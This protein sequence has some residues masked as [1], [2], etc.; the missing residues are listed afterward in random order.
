[1]KKTLGLLLLTL[2]VSSFAFQEVKPSMME[3]QE[4]IGGPFGLP[5]YVTSK[6]NVSF[7]QKHPS[8]AFIFSPLVQFGGAMNSVRYDQ[9][10]KVES[11]SLNPMEKSEGWTEVHR[12]RIEVGAGLSELARRTLSIGLSGYKGAIHKL[13]KSSN[14]DIMYRAP[15]ILQPKE[16]SE[17][18]SWSVGD[19]GSFENYGGIEAYAGLVLGP[20]ELTRAILTLQNQ[21]QIELKKISETQVLFAISETDVVKR[22]LVLGHTV[23]NSI[24]SR[25]DG[26]RFAAEFTLDLTNPLHHELFSLGLKG[27]IKDVQDKL[28]F[29]TQKLTWRGQNTYSFVGIPFTFGFN[30]NDGHYDL[31]ENGSESE[32]DF[33]IR[34]N[35]GIFLSA[36][37]VQRFVYQTEDQLVLYWASEMDKVIG[38]TLDKYFLSVG[39]KIGLKGFESTLTEKEPVGDVITQLGLTFNRDE[40]EE[41]KSIHIASL[42]QNL[43]SRCQ[44][45]RLSC[46]RAQV[47]Q[48]LIRDFSNSLTLEWKELIHN[49]G[50]T[51]AKEPALVH[52]ML[53]TLGMQKEV[54]F[55]F[56]NN[57]F[58]SLEGM[59]PV[60]L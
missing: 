55:K 46:A 57:R 36:R 47:S 59:A 54:Y 48:K 30:F 42:T 16:L 25:V 6:G 58:Q 53:K 32:V 29:E 5:F 15:L 21:F 45:L 11:F 35:S 23:A 38:K 26:K 37:S 1:M 12:R 52:S 3:T 39:R 18:E 8:D 19:Y 2:S 27:K 10:N 50:N 28:S 13:I 14:T 41:I 24:L 4:T 7:F 51:L 33:S 56:L 34:K 44:E 31:N 49:L 9:A 22:R 43:I 20:L 40:V 60:I 17:V